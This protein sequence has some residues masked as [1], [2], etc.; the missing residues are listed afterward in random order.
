MKESVSSRL[1]PRRIQ[2]YDIIWEEL[3]DP[4]RIKGELSVFLGLVMDSCPCIKRR[5]SSV[6]ALRQVLQ[7]HMICGR[8][9]SQTMDRLPVNLER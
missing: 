5:R 9:G 4:T 1:L 2:C 8:E 7:M 6:Q 3:K